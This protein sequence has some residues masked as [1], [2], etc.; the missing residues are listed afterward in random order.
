MNGVVV[1]VEK[2]R[3]NDNKFNSCGVGCLLLGNAKD[4]GGGVEK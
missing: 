2:T 1:S 3:I 4:D